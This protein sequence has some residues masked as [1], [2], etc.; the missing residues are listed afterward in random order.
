MALSLKAGKKNAFCCSEFEAL[1]G[2]RKLIKSDSVRM[3]SP[4]G[5]DNVAESTIIK[6]G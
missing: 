1:K 5:S 4:E 2:A 6:S 3:I